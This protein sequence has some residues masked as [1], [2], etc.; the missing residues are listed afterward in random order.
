MAPCGA[1]CVPPCISDIDT[2]IET[3]E[4][5]AGPVTAAI[6]P[7]RGEP[8]PQAQHHHTPDPTTSARRPIT[9]LRLQVNARQYHR[10]LLY[11][12]CSIDYA[13]ITERTPHGTGLQL[14]ISPVNSRGTVSFTVELNFGN[15]LYLTRSFFLD[16]ES[17]LSVNFVD[18]TRS[19]PHATRIERNWEME[20]KERGG[21]KDAAKERDSK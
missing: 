16:K 6:Q 19:R 11:Y 9:R 18:A 1:L 8:S 13:G 20:G 4:C 10:L 2:L 14:S 17:K 12:S 5:R 3:R 21:G 15:C 7:L